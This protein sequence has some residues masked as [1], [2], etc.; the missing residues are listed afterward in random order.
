[1]NRLD[2]RHNTQSGQPGQVFRVNDL[3]VLDPVGVVR[4]V[5]VRF[6]LP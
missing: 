5:V 6:K 2:R 3:D 1:M 4:Q